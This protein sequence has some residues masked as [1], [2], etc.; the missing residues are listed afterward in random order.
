MHRGSTSRSLT[1]FIGQ[2]REWQ[3]ANG[4]TTWL[5]SMLSRARRHPLLGLPIRA[6]GPADGSSPSKTSGS[7]PSRGM[8]AGPL[9]PKAQPAGSARGPKG[10]VVLRGH[11]MPAGQRT[12]CFAVGRAPKRLFLC[13]Y[14]PNESPDECHQNM[15]NRH[16]PLRSAPIFGPAQYDQQELPRQGVETEN[17]Q[18]LRSLASHLQLVRE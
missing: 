2:S 13:H 10:L 4:S 12:G 3:V 15:A 1:L 18:Q 11:V 7:R 9:W 14:L 8:A 16:L 6:G 5:T 17:R